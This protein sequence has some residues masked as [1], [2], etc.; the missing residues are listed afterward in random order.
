[1]LSFLQERLTLYCEACDK[2][3]CRDCQLNYHK[4]HRYKFI[5]EIA[6]ETKT[7]INSLLSEVK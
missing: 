2:L 5:D 3:T 4:L 1:M 7:T 6:T